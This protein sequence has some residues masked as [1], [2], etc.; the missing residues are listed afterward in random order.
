MGPTS[1]KPLPYKTPV[2][3]HLWS[4]QETGAGI[5]R[6]LGLLAAQMETTRSSHV[7]CSASLG[8]ISWSLGFLRA[9]G[10]CSF[11]APLSHVRINTKRRK[12][13]WSQASPGMVDRCDQD[14]RMDNLNRLS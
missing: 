1:S 13:C 10:F 4:Q 5:P 14:L 7:P 2:T 3:W 6:G 9:L 11:E 8:V 12:R